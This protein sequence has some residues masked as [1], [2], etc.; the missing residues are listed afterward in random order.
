MPA[1]LRDRRLLTLYAAY[2]REHVHVRDTIDA[3][4][5]RL[6]RSLPD[7]RDESISR[8]AA[9]T[10]TV[11][12]AGQRRVGTITDA[13][14]T[15]RQVL[16]AG[17]RPPSGSVP[18]DA[19]DDEAIRGVPATEVYGRTGPEVW[20]ALEAGKPLSDA[21]EAGLTRARKMAATDLQLAM[22][23][24]AQHSAKRRGVKWYRRELA[25]SNP[26][27]LCVVASTQRYHVGT[28]MPIHPA[29]HCEVAEEYSAGDPGRVIDPDRLAHAHDAIRERFGAWD[30]GSREI[31]A[32]NPVTGEALK[33]QD[34]LFV[35]EHGELGP[36]L[37]VRGQN[38]K[39][40]DDI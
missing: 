1:V 38:F 32:D 16:F 35:H 30:A 6:W 17:E 3:H 23:H 27:G 7:Y 9:T 22:T 40:P 4:I 19:L 14:L 5:Q 15:R 25:S 31:D 13:Y 26:C 20:R 2:H 39:G 12:T 21:V 28:L 29:C 10:A 24:S 37:G 8:F 33:Y 34:V 36:V 11:V 18:L